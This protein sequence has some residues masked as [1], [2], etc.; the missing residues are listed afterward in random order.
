MKY[1]K[2]YESTE[3]EYMDIKKYL[4]WEMKQNLIIL[5]V[6][7]NKI[8]AVEMKRLFVYHIEYDKLRVA[9]EE[10]F[11]FNYE[12]VKKH[13]IYDTDDLESIL[14]EEVLKPLANINKY[15]I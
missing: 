15:N 12:K 7:S 3:I 1:I 5:E 14:N 13:V 2:A 4:V 6:L 10:T 9:S 11:T 8:D